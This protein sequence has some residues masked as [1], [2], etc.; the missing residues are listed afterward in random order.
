MGMGD[1]R[2][3]ERKARS[4]QQSAANKTST[5]TVQK[6]S[7]STTQKSSTTTKHT[8]IVQLAKSGGAASTSSI[9]STHKFSGAA[10]QFSSGMGGLRVTESKI[11]SNSSSPTKFLGAAKQS[12]PGMGGLRVA[13]A[14]KLGEKNL[15]TGKFVD[16]K[17]TSKTLLGTD[18]MKNGPSNAKLNLGKAQVSRF[19]GGPGGVKGEAYTVETGVEIISLDNPKNFLGFTAGVDVNTGVVKGGL[20]LESDKGLALG[21]LGGGAYA[22]LKEGN[23][24]AKLRVGNLNV[25]ANVGGNV[26]GIGAMG[27]VSI[28]DRRSDDSY[29]IFSADGL[30]EFLVGANVN[31][32]IYLQDKKS[33]H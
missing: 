17:A 32:D 14:K 33:K 5:S 4:T 8:P 28:L 18:N 27:E 2:V 10:K 13:E 11:S 7:T 30:L 19:S 12:S 20:Y 1:L 21:S 23:L 26:A 24:H 6:T 29:H 31:I 16:D 9:S 3:A 25:Y 15:G 22:T